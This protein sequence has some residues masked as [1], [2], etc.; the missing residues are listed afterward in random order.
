MKK[1]ILLMVVALL[2]VGVF[3]AC[4]GTHNGNVSDT[5][6]GKVNGGKNT[7]STSNGVL[8]DLDRAEDRLEPTN[9]GVTGDNNGTT[10]GTNGNGTTNG[11]GTNGTVNGNGTTNGTNGSGTNGTGTVTGNGTNGNGTV[12]GNGTNGNNTTTTGTGT[13]NAQ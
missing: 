13:R 8:D 3:T 2:I 6:N 11:Y 7:E 5:N 4:T 10:N 9:N 12:N 1:L